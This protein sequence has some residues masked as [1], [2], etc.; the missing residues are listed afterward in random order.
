[1]DINHYTTQ[2]NWKILLVDDNPVNLSL[3][4]DFL[5]AQNYEVMI[6][7]SGLEAL[8]IMRSYLPDLILLDIAMPE[9]D[10]YEVCKQ[11][12]ANELTQAVPVIFISALN[13][14]VDQV[15]A[16]DVGGVDYITKPF[17]RKEVLARVEN[18]M[19]IA[20]LQKELRSRNEELLKRNEELQASQQRAEVIFSTLTEVLPGTVLDQKYRLDTKIGFGGFGAVYKATHLN[21]NR[22][23]AVKV[24][25]PLFGKCSPVELERFRREGILACHINHPNAVSVLDSNISSSG[26]AYLVMELLEG[27]TLRDELNEKNKLSL[28]RCAQIIVPVCQVLAKAHSMGIVHRDIKPENIFLHSSDG[29]E[30]IKVVDFGIAKVVD[31]ASDLLL[32]SVTGPGMLPGTINYIS[33]ERLTDKPFDGRADVYSLGIMMY[34]MLSGCLP[35]QSDGRNIARVLIEHITKEPIPLNQLNSNIPDGVTAVVKKALSKEMKERPT[36]EDLALEFL[37]AIDLSEEEL[38]RSGEFRSVSVET[39]NTG[40]N[41]QT[42][43]Y[44]GLSHLSNSSENG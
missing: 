3:L 31:D 44:L 18:Q 27:C 38:N 24:F 19:R 17:R 2:T 25:R 42:I 15:R 39:L 35:F 20:A 23:V 16:F 10:G 7:S 22:P 8:K 37:A 41:I 21:L 14:V 29:H 40:T 12:K 4:E 32:E 28:F 26:I 9:M 13:D 5:V 43:Q 6:A 11:L 1:M 34:E 30:V 36:A 33:P